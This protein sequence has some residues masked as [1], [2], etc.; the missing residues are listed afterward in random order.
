MDST[1]TVRVTLTYA[2]TL[3]RGV[4]DG[5]VIHGQCTYCQSYSDIRGYFDKRDRGWSGNWW[6]VRVLSELPWHTWI[7]WQ[8]GI[9]DGVVIHG[10]YA[11]CQSYSDI[12]G[13][14]DKDGVVIHWQ[15]T[16]CQ[17][18][19]D[20]HR[21]SDK[22]GREWTIHVLPWTFRDTLDFKVGNWLNMA[23]LD[24][25]HQSQSCAYIPWL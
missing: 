22:G 18:Y 19:S 7:L 5:V 15:N 12:Y 9:G 4:G 20:M 16:Y 8:G 1:R 21:Y 6:T 17:G 11:Y 24:I 10:Q 14:S 25:P 13:Y 23:P 2:D 3:T